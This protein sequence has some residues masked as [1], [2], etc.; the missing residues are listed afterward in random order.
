MRAVL[1]TI[2]SILLLGG[3]AVSRLAATRPVFGQSA[4]VSGE[5]PDFSS[6][7]CNLKGLN[8]EQR[9][10]KAKL[11][12]TLFSLPIGGRELANGYEIQFPADSSTFQ[13]VVEWAVMER[14]CCQFF[15]IELRLEREGGPF[16][17]RLTGREGVKEFMRAEFRPEWLK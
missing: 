11:D 14:A 16:W 10:R 12:R 3:F 8:P 5:K 15:D 4:R 1:R 2:A 6:F 7:L 17:L 13:T 9:K